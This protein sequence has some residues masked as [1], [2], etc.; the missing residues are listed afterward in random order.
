VFHSLG[1]ESFDGYRTTL[2]EKVMKRYV[3]M[4]KEKVNFELGKQ[5]MIMTICC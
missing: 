1:F 4:L 2:A 5:K 3:N